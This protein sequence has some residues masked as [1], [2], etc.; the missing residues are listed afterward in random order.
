MTKLEE[1]ISC[2]KGNS[3]YVQMHN[4][5]DPDAIASAYGMKYLL[6][7]E[8]IDAQ[9]VYK[10]SIENTVTAKMVKLLNID[11]LEVKSAWELDCNRE[12]IIVDA[13]NGNANIIDMHS[14]KT[15]CIDHHPVYNDSKYVF[16]D[17][18]PDVG[19]CA[20]I[21]ASYYIENDVVIDIHMATAL[22]LSL[23]HI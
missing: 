1:I 19:A 16:K 17:I 8:G 13:Q 6:R 18:R 7:A 10:G 15:I 12:V 2:I 20:S 21:I 5:P 23:I 4:F 14:D 22:L 11:I 9:I 3:V